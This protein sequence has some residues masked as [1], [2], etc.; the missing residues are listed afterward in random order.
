MPSTALHRPGDEDPRSGG[1]GGG[2]GVGDF[3]QP[4]RPGGG[5]VDGGDTAASGSDTNGGSTVKT[6]ADL[7]AQ[8]LNQPPAVAATPTVVPTSGSSFPILPLVL[9]LG[10]GVAVWYFFLRKKTES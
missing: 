7:I 4:S 8:G 3:T 5:G 6:I 2:I 1:D 10:A 9:I